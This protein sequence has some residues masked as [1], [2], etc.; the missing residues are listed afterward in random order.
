[1]HFIIFFTGFLNIYIEYPQ[2][3]TCERELHLEQN[4]SNEN[5]QKTA[6]FSLYLGI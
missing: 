3:T 5:M 1:M 2:S 6:L 4:P